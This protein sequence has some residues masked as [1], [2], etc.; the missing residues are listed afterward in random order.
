MPRLTILQAYQG[1]ARPAW[2][3]LCLASV[4]DW[5]LRHGY[6]HVFTDRLFDRVPSWFHRHCGPENGPMTDLGRTMLMQ[7]CLD[8]GSNGSGGPVCWV[9]ADVLVFAPDE[10]RL[11]P[12]VGL[13]GVRE[14]TPLVDDEGVLSFSAA[15]IN[16]AVL[17][18]AAGGTGLAAYA[19]AIEVRVAAAPAGAVPRTIAG[20]LLLTELA[21]SLDIAV[22]DHVG[23]VTPALGGELLRGET[24]IAAAY[25]RAFGA[26]LHAAN[27]CHFAR[28]VVAPAR[29][30]EYD[31][32][33][34]RLVALLR[35]SGGSVI[36]DAVDV[37]DTPSRMIR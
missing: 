9:D 18:E 31:R 4:R 22:F 32:A 37:P 6:H 12:V 1:D 11:P 10:L 13:T 8:S 15:G 23:L 35:D 26:P 2:I 7:D 29:R 33:M 27:L 34:L 21:L 5:A 28:G 24:R 3:D 36:N 20:P 19:R 16:G 25:A 30:S 17:A 14:I